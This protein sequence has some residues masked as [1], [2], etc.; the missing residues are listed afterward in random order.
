MV[1][2]FHVTLLNSTAVE[3]TW[4]PPTSTVGINGDIRG[5]RLYVDQVNGTLQTINIE[6]DFARE[7]LVTDLQPSATYLFSIL[8]YTIADGPQSVR[9]QVTM[10]DGSKYSS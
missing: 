8:I 7:Y 10:P 5:F 2:N 4:R 6:D 1:T 9:L 3:V